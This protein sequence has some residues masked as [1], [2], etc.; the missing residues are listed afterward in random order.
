MYFAEDFFPDGN[1]DFVA[2]TFD[3]LAKHYEATYGKDLR[4][5]YESIGLDPENLAGRPVYKDGLFTELKAIGWVVEDYQCAQISINL[6][7][8]K[9]TSNVCGRKGCPHPQWRTPVMD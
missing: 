6:T 9:V 3:E 2:S 4:Q 8:Y 7:N 1:S 5:R